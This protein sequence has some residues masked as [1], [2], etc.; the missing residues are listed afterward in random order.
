MT[1]DYVN[2]AAI[3]LMIVMVFIHSSE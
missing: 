1:T 3:L 2:I